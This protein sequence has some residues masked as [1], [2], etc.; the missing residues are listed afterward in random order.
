MKDSS[1]GNQSL[2]KRKFSD[3]T[4]ITPTH[5]KKETQ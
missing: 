3:L 1:V 2:G 5:L 4:I